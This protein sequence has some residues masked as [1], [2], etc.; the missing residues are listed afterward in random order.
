MWT[1][2]KEKLLNKI[3]ENR[4]QLVSL[5]KTIERMVR[6]KSASHKLKRKYT[7]KYRLIRSLGDLLALYDIKFGDQV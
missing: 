5:N 2:G 3:T 7:K 1:V 4:R 6:A